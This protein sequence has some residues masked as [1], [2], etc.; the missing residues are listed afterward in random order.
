VGIDGFP[1]IAAGDDRLH[2]ADAEEGQLG[3]RVL[4]DAAG[5]GA[6]V[7]GGDDEVFVAIPDDLIGVDDIGEEGVEIAAA[8][9]DQFRADF[10][11]AAVELVAGG[12]GGREDGLAVR[13]IRFAG[14]G[15]LLL[16][17]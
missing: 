12:A 16:L 10:L 8:R 11:T 6:V 9:A 5:D 15:G 1:D 2:A 17:S 14:E 13:E 3:G 7:F 4:D